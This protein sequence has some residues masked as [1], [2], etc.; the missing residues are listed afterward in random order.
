MPQNNANKTSYLPAI[1]MSIAC[2]SS[3]R[4]EKIY[5]LGIEGFDKSDRNHH[6]GEI[7]LTCQNNWERRK[8]S[9]NSR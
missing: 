2:R 8:S 3:S 1:A 6:E 5:I 9:S 7:A 4:G